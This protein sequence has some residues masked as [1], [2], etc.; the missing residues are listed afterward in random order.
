MRG[1]AGKLARPARRVSAIVL[2]AIAVLAAGCGSSSPAGGPGSAGEGTSRV[3]VEAKSLARVGT[4]LVTPSGAALYMFVP[5]KQRRVTCKGY[6]AK[7]WPPLKL[8][9]GATLAAGSGVRQSLL[10]SDPDPSGGRVVTYNGWPLYTYS[11]DVQAGQTAGQGIN[12]N[13]G[14]WFVMR[15]SGQPLRTAPG[16]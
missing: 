1:G 2:A 6:C 3:T 12:L 4:V 16:G 5:D 8:P 9:A 14:A 11:A 7:I 10:G 13:G 15:P